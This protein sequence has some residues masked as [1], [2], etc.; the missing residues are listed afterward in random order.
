MQAKHRSE[1]EQFKSEKIPLEAEIQVLRNR[2]KAEKAQFIELR[3]SDSLFNQVLSSE[4][5]YL[6]AL[7]IS[8]HICCYILVFTTR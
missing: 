7:I 4:V 1:K 3:I 8:T 5:V 6:R 2:L